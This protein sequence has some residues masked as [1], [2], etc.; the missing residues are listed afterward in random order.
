M[1][2]ASRLATGYLPHRYSGV[3]CLTS[4]SLTGIL[5]IA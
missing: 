3:H 1:Q 4:W 2:Q 5:T